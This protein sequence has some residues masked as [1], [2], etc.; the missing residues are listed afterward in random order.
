LLNRQREA[1]V[2]P[3]ANRERHMV[4]TLNEELTT[5][6]NGNAVLI[7]MNLLST[8]HSLSV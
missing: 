1:G 4:D 3:N 8:I 5:G 2:L 6:T 7:V